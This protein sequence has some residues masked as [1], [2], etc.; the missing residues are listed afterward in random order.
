M[1]RCIRRVCAVLAVLAGTLPAPAACFHNGQWLMIG[2][3]ALNR[4]EKTPPLRITEDDR[5]DATEYKGYVMG[6]ADTQ[7]EQAY[8][9]PAGLTSRQVMDTVGRYAERNPEQWDGPAPELIV[10]A[11]KQSY[12]LPPKPVI[13]APPPAPAK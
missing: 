9:L 7:N 3:K 13:L 12:P 10:R 1:K 8:Q 5:L 6:V 2:W 4:M 11:L